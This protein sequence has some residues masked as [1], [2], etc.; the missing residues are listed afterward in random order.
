MECHLIFL[1]LQALY[2]ATTADT[3]FTESRAPGFVSPM[4]RISFLFFA[5]LYV[6]FPE[7]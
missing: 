4:C 2:R 3:L 1:H 6:L 5:C 7:G